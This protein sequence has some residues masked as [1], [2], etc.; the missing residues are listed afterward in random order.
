MVSKK[1]LYY[2][3]YFQKM[4]GADLYII[5]SLNIL[6]GLL[7]GLSLMMFVPLLGA[8][9]NSNFGTLGQFQF[10][11]NGFEFIGLSMSLMN[12]LLVMIFLFCIKAIINYFK[13]LYA[14]KLRQTTIRNTRYSLMDKFHY[15]TY[16]GFTRANAGSIQH[17]M[18]T[19]SMKLSQAMIQ[20]TL[21]L[22]NLTIVLVYLFLAFWADWKFSILALLGGGI[23][24]IFYNVI[25]K[26]IVKR[27][28][29]ISHLGVRFNKHLVQVIH[30]F[31]YLKVTNL[32]AKY[33]LYLRDTIRDFEEQNYRL[34]KLNSITSNIREPIVVI[35][36]AI[37]ILIYVNY[38]GHSLGGILIGLLLFYR[39]LNNLMSLQQSWSS[40]L[41][42]T[43]SIGAIEQLQLYFEQNK[44]EHQV[45]ETFGSIDT[46]RL[47][48]LSLHIGDA[49]ILKDINMDIHAKQ[50]IAFVGESGAGKTSLANVISG[51]LAPT[52]GNIV[53]NSK[54]L[55]NKRLHAY[56]DRIGYVTQEPVI[57]DGTIFENVSFWD[58]KKPENLANFKRCLD[59]VHLT[60]FVESVK[61]KENTQLGSN[62]ILVSGGQKQRIAIARELYRNI[63]LLIMDEA[64]SALDSETESTIKSNLDNLKGQYTMIIIAH[65]LST[66]KNVDK[67]YVLRGGDIIDFGSYEELYQSSLDFRKMVDLQEL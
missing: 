46:I 66:I 10:L 64:T 21:S 33:K 31:K 48:N 9:S 26:Q 15:L 35:I 44:D 19:E 25:N 30:N 4:L 65:R 45:G 52:Q 55:D 14:I 3:K 7:D 41:K 20:Y 49:Q 5:V 38:F 1:F 8:L 23:S 40:F 58:D 53:V 17:A 12:V 11:I 67:I 27:A 59:V 54:G 60:P 57:F 22:Q 42:D 50:T 63:D 28:K 39:L 62:G 32:F 18:V 16:R 13:S 61:L 51:L 24:F 6:T 29:N 47:Q 37:V 34:G 2:F 36:I 43:A 56:R